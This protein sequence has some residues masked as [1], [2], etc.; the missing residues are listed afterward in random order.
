M[1]PARVGNFRQKVMPPKP[2]PSTTTWGS[3]LLPWSMQDVAKGRREGKRRP[4]N[5][6]FFSDRTDLFKRP[7]RENTAEHPDHRTRSG[8]RLERW[9]GDVFPRRGA[10]RRLAQRRDAR[11]TGHLGQ[12]IWRRRA[13]AIRR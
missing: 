10:P 9:D 1:R 12:P 11:R 6:L 5:L 2:A 13:E 4:I 3:A 7:V 8:H